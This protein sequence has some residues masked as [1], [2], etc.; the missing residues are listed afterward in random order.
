MIIC[1]AI[2]FYIESTKEEVVL[3]GVRHGDIFAQLKLLG[4][5]PQQGYLEIKQ[6]FLTDDNVFLNRQEA[7]SYAKQCG[8]I[9]T[10][11]ESGTL[12][13]EDLW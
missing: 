12:Y 7:F 1:S 5:K 13:S 4:F 11:K 3:C 8:Q 10:E 9:E 6:G 2:K